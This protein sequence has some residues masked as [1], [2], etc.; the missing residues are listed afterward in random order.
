[1]KKIQLGGHKR[2][3]Q[4]RGYALV[5]DDVFDRLKRYKW[6]IDKAGYAIRQWGTHFRVR[7]ILMAREILGI[8]EKKDLFTDHINGDRLDNR[9]E[10]LRI[11]TRL[12]NNRNQT[13]L[14]KNNS[15]GF[16]G[17]YLDKRRKKFEAYVTINKKHKC[18]GYFKT[19]KEAANVYNKAAERFYGNFACLNKI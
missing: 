10:N 7:R 12:E 9:C 11:A 3:S 14:R 15:T 13:I 6:S 2:G 1:M 8:L 16:K 17:V 4:I 5:D 18:L 19:P